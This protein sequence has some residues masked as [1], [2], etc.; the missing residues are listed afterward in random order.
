MNSEGPLHLQSLWAPESMNF[1]IF[2]TTHTSRLSSSI[3]YWTV[4]QASK[5]MKWFR[6]WTAVLKQFKDIIIIKSQ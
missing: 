5:T 1:S 3:S 4:K 6:K 2:I